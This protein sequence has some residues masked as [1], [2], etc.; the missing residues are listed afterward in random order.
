ME[1]CGEMP[2]SDVVYR[3]YDA[4]KLIA[5]AL[6]NASDINDPDSIREAFLGI[7]A[8]EGIA[9]TYNFSDGSGDGLSTAR[10]YIVKDGKNTLFEG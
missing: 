2:V 1:K 9:G 7:T 4:A 3:G 8:F 10:V 6:R 5:E